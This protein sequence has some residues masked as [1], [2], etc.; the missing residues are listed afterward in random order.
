[1]ATREMPSRPGPQ[2]VPAAAAAPN[3]SRP[4]AVVT[5]LF[6]M[7]GFLTCLNDILVPHL[8]AIFDL[9]YARVMLVQFAFFSAYFL[10]SVPWSKVVNT[11][12]YQRTMVIGLFTMAFGAFLFLPAASAASYPLFLTALLVLA[13]GI[14]GLQVSANP[15]VDLLGTPETASS[16]LDLTQAFNSLGTTLAPKVGGLLILAAAPLAMEQLRKL[17]PA[18]L[19]AYRVQE[20][21]SVKMPYAVIGVL[22]VL[23]AI[24]IGSFNLPKVEAGEYRLRDK[25]SDSIW[26]H[27]NLLLGAIG[28]FTYVGAEVSIG[29]FLVNYFGLPDIASLSAKT[30]A[31]YVSFYWG[32]SMVGRFLGAGLLRRFKPGR[33]LAVFAICAATLVAASM[34]LGGH[35]AMWTILAV[36]LFNSIM[37]PTIFSLGVAELG[38]LTGSGS[39]LLNMAIVGGAILPVIQGGIADRVGL[40]HAFVLPVMC[41]LYIL[42]YGLSGS[43]PNSERYVTA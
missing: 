27:P 34:V 33:L 21:A 25:V 31:G 16:R 29:S 5:T 40:H 38:P 43:K 17:S 19:H 12:G 2:G 7:W 3:Y 18:A 32:G 20:A 36:G 39:G 9:S 28:I 4:L 42:F 10:F 6:F 11:V 37:F 8:K 22:L 13:A 1:M 23:L 26:K 24:M 14:T 15:Y 41:Y 35:T 30:A